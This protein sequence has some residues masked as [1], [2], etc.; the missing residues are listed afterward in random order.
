MA[1]VQFKN[2]TKRFGEFNAVS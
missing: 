1:S 2:I